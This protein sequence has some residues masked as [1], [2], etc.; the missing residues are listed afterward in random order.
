MQH[1][2]TASDSN[3]YLQRYATGSITNMPKA[4]FPTTV[5]LS[6][7]A[8]SACTSNMSSLQ[9]AN[10]TKSNAKQDQNVKRHAN[11]R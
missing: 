4:M 5:V 11:E 2:G 6:L 1:D 7:L 8:A 3:Y 9:S 10:V